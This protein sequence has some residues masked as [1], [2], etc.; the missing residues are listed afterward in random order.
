MANALRHADA[1]LQKA[2]RKAI[3]VGLNYVDHAKEMGSKADRIAPIWFFKPSTSYLAQ[4]VGPIQIP[5]TAVAHYEVELGVVIGRPA[6]DVKAS[7]AIKHIAGYVCAIDVTARNWQSE[8]KKLGRP[9]AIAKGCD[10]F[11]PLS[12]VL[13][14]DSITI[15]GQ[16]VVDVN[17]YLDVNGE[18][19]QEGSTKDMI[20]TIPELIEHISSHVTLEEWDLIL[21]GT[22]SGVGEFRPGDKI[23]AGIEGLVEMEFGAVARS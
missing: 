23:K 17:L 10:T 9:W 13:P 16:G 15:D 2:S 4:N 6:K 12:N 3:A 7:D 21:T 14:P 20:W 8:A 11:L 18:R 1:L 19:R 22:P 5:P